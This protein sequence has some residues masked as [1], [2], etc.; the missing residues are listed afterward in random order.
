MDLYEEMIK[1]VAKET[2]GTLQFNV[3]GFEI[4]LDQKWPRIKYADLLK[5]KFDVDV[6]N[7][8]R[9]QLVRILKENGVEVKPDTTTSHLIDNVWKL[10]RKTSAGPYWLIEEPLSL[11]PLAKVVPE[12]PL[13]TQRFHPVIA[14]T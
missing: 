7:P 8:D 11:S 2:W 6:F 14:G 5:E 13:V 1:Y 12:N 9:E 10:I 4:N 3:G